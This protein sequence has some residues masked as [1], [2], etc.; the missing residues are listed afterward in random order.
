MGFTL[1]DCLFG[2]VKLT[3][4]SDPKKFGYSGYGIRFDARSQ[5]LLLIGQWGKIVVIFGV[6]NS[7]SRYTEKKI[8]QFFVRG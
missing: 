8:S 1:G 6:D 4:S 5:F 3:K 2:A 7:P